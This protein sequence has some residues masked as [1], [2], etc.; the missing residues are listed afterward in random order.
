[1]W[2]AHMRE[3]ISLSCHIFNKIFLSYSGLRQAVEERVDRA[4]SIN[5]VAVSI[6]VGH[7]QEYQGITDPNCYARLSRKMRAAI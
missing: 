1:M 3:K 7:D 4:V 6:D 2:I 5:R